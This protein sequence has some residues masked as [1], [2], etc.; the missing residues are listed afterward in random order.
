MAD[1]EIREMEE[2]ADAAAQRAA[3]DSTS[4]ADSLLSRKYVVPFFLACIIVACTQA[5]GINGILSFVVNILNQAGLP[6]PRPTAPTRS[7]RPS[8]AWRLWWPCSWLIAWWK[9]R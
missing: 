3:A 4:P 2:T 1:L 6:G 5:T 7:S 9:F 8:I